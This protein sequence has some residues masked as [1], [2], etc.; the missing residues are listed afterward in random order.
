MADSSGQTNGSLKPVSTLQS[1]HRPVTL[2]VYPCPPHKPSTPLDDWLFPVR[3]VDLS[4]RITISLEPSAVPGPVGHQAW[5][6]EIGQEQCILPKPSPKCCRRASARS[7]ALPA[8][9]TRGRVRLNHA[10]PISCHRP[11]AC[12]FMRSSVKPRRI[13]A[14]NGTITPSGA[15]P[16]VTRQSVLV[17]KFAAAH[18]P[19]RRFQ[20]MLLLF[21][22]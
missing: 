17:A 7:P 10:R 21:A 5:H 13:T 15:L 20:S 11:S 12:S 18:S 3:D 22:R 1:L 6:P 4:N 19:R 14:R 16:T 2:G 9:V 8:R